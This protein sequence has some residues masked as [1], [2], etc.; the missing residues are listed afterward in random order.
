MPKSA[1]QIANAMLLSVVAILWT[2]IAQLPPDEWYTTEEAA[3]LL[4][5]PTRRMR[6]WIYA[7]TVRST[8]LPGGRGRRVSGAA[9]NEAM[10]NEASPAAY[11]V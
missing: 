8:V 2:V 1:T 10:A 7:G 3:Q 6:R 11:K 9:L 4:K 5:V